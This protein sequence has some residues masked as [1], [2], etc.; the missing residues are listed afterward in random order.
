MIF[1]AG[2]VVGGSVTAV[3]LTR[4]AQDA[5]QHP[6]Q[7]PRRIAKQLARRLDLDPDQ[8]REV[9]HILE[10]RQAPLLKARA[11]ML[12]RAEPELDLLEADVAGVLRPG[13]AERWRRHYRELRRTWVPK[14]PQQPPHPEDAA[15]ERPGP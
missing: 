14:L 10:R 13:Q 8:V 2:G 11:A 15:P 9:E 3:A 4:R 5:I 12:R 7:M 1:L 6:E